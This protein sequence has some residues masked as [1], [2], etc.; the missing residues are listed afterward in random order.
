L[1]AKRGQSPRLQVPPQSCTDEHGQQGNKTMNNLIATI[2]RLG[3]LKAM[4]A[5][6]QA[7]EK[8][9][10]AVLIEQGPGSYEGSMYDASVSMTERETLDMAAVREY[11][12]RQF[13]QA[14]TNVTPVTTVRVVARKGARKAA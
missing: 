7:E 1:K 4:I 6:L 9:L 13:I 2:D 10:K 3:A 5:E 12:S 8:E 14:H 11:L